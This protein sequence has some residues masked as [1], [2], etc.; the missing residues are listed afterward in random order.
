M[1]HSTLLHSNGGY[2]MQSVKF[3]IIT[4]LLRGLNMVE[5]PNKPSLEDTHCT[6]IQHEVKNYMKYGIFLSKHFFIYFA[7][8]IHE[9]NTAVN[10]IIITDALYNM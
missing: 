6:C 3:S 2:E 5:S 7:V 10:V 1:S 4:L 8:R 9:L